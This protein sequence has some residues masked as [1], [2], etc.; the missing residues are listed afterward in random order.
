MAHSS[1]MCGTHHSDAI[2]AHRHGESIHNTSDAPFTGR[3]LNTTEYKK[4]NDFILT[5]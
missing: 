2:A 4:V 5:V 1:E 3:A